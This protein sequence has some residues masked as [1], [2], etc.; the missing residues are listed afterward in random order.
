[1]GHFYGRYQAESQY[2]H[3]RVWLLRA[4]DTAGKPLSWIEFEHVFPQPSS[5]KEAQ[6]E[7]L[8]AVS[9]LV[10]LEETVHTSF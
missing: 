5:V 2:D 8:P 1:V 7:G 9:P 10:M 4:F 3:D 6:D